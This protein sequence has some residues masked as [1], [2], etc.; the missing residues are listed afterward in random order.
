MSYKFFK[1]KPLLQSDAPLSALI[2][3]RPDLRGFFSL[4]IWNLLS[5]YVLDTLL[6][7]NRAFCVGALKNPLGKSY[8]IMLP[9]NTAEMKKQTLPVRQK[10]VLLAL[11]LAQSLKVESLSFA[12][13]LPS[14]LNHFK[15]YP[16]DFLPF[17]DKI[18]T[19]HITSSLALAWLF[20]VIVKQ[21]PYY[22]TFC[23]VGVGSIGQKSLQLLLQKV[24][25]PKQL[26]LCDLRK[27]EKTIQKLAREIRTQYQIPVAISY[28]N[29]ESF[30]KIYQAD[31]IL[32]AVS[33]KKI[34]KPDLLKK[35]T[36]LIDDSFPP[37]LSVP[38]S[39]R[40]M[41]TKKDVLILT[42][43]KLDIGDFEFSIHLSQ[44]FPFLLSLLIKQLGIQSLPGCWAEALLS[45]KGFL[46][47]QDLLKLWE[48]KSTWN[49][50][51]GDLH[52]LKYSIPE[53]L[54]NH[55]Y[56]IRKQNF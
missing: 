36:I 51:P 44:P 43:G 41:K 55:V 32:G 49:I 37:M 42:G 2:M 15:P 47:S 48:E 16:K 5:Q 26:I 56:K 31:L 1:K 22:H 11:K 39:L 14:L 53:A 13:L 17:K 10:Q 6:T 24:L 46:K 35:G 28:Y 40:R 7:K 19:G 50:K 25:K 52:C 29:E 20:D 33:S 34:L 38:Q 23:L 9:Y 8:L 4:K 3:C 18:N 12:G 45:S 21:C 27:K 30:L 54:K